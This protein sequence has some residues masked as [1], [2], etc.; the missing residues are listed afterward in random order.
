MYVCIFKN[1]HPIEK[2][3][4]ANENLEKKHLNLAFSFLNIAF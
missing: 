4:M 2:I 1:S 3:I